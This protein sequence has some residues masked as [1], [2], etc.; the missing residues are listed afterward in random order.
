M[1]HDCLIVRLEP[2]RTPEDEDTLVQT[3]GLFGL[4]SSV[5]RDNADLRFYDDAPSDSIEH[6]YP[7]SKD[8][9]RKI[10]TYIVDNPAWGIVLAVGTNCVLDVRTAEYVYDLGSV[11]FRVPTARAREVATYEELVEHTKVIRKP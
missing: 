5:T 11:E 7:L 9:R 1:D 8:V 3:I 4:V 10:A 6:I 2:N